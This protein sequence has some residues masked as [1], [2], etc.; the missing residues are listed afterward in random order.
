MIPEHPGVVHALQRHR[1]EKPLRE[2]YFTAGWENITAVCGARVKVH[3][4][5]EFDPGDEDACQR[6]VVVAWERDHPT[7]V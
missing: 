2:P 7:P 3:L 6:C 5:L 4:P 1:R